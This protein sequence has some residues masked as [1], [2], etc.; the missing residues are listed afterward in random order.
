L[1]T[2]TLSS[3]FGNGTALQFGEATIDK[4]DFSKQDLRRSNFTAASCRSCKFVKT[5]LN[6]EERR[7]GERD[8][9]GKYWWGLGLDAPSSPFH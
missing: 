4:K 8:G 2:P 9:V 1:A 6:G 5:K 7:G 3:E